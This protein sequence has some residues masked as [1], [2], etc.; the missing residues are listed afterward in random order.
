MDSMNGPFGTGSKRWIN[1]ALNN[2][3]ATN[4]CA[5]LQG[6]TYDANAPIILVWEANAENTGD[7]MTLFARYTKNQNSRAQVGEVQVYSGQLSTADRRALECA[8]GR[9]WGVTITGYTCTQA[10]GV[11]YGY[12]K[13]TA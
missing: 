3:S 9:K 10:I 12:V 8:L 2:P 1:G 4:Q 5:V 11:T 13:R 6:S 7:Q